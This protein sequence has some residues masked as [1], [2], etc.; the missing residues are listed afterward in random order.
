MQW[1]GVVV[2]GVVVAT[3][4]KKF[5]FFVGIHTMAVKIGTTTTTAAITVGMCIESV[6]IG[7]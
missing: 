2:T 4:K 6:R 5:I 1:N 3:E 7:M